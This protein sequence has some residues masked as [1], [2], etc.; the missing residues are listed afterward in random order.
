MIVK[1][2]KSVFSLALCL[3]LPL[4]AHA[5]ADQSQHANPFATSGIEIATEHFPGDYTKMEIRIADP[6]DIQVGVDRLD[7]A[8]VNLD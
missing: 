2:K 8:T 5:A 6:Q 4:A 1:H 3:F 7:A